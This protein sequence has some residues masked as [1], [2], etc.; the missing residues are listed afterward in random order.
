MR[1]RD[2]SINDLEGSKGRKGIGPRRIKARA[3]QIFPISE[4]TAGY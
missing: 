2:P 1:A 4:T 3:K